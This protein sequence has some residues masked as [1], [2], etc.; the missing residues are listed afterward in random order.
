MKKLIGVMKDPAEQPLFA[1][2]VYGEHHSGWFWDECCQLGGPGNY[3]HFGSA[4]TRENKGD[5]N[6]LYTTAFTALYNTINCKPL[7]EKLS[8][9]IGFDPLQNFGKIF[10]SLNEKYINEDIPQSP[11]TGDI[12][13]IPVSLMLV[14]ALSISIIIK[15]KY[16]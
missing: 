6:Y 5:G 11:D 1:A 15:K 13:F 7:P 3:K 12:I 16:A 4:H 10:L 9:G 2:A 14:C 8:S